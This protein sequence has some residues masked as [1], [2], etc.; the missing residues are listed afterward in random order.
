ML[1]VFLHEL[2]GF[3]GGGVVDVDD[4]VVVVVLHEQGV[5][6]AQVQAGGDVVVGWDHDAEG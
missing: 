3:V 4:V 1:E 2:A 6:V 5:Q